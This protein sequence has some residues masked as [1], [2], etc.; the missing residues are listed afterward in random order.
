M[1]GSESTEERHPPRPA[2]GPRSQHRNNIGILRLAFACLVI[3]AHSYEFIDGNRH[4]EPLTRLFGSGVPS[5]GETSVLAFFVISG[6]L[7]T[8]SFISSVKLTNY[9]V[10]R[11]ARIVPGYVVAFLLSSTVVAALAGT[12]L[13]HLTGAELR[14]LFCNL[15]L[16]ES[17]DMPN[18][19]VG[20]PYPFLNGSLWT[21]SYEARCYLFVI[22]FGLLGWHDRRRLYLY[23]TIIL[24]ISTALLDLGLMHVP[25]RFTYSAVGRLFYSDPAWMVRF[26][27]V[28]MIGA[29]FRLFRG[30]ILYRAD[31]AAISVACIAV[32]LYIHVLPFLAMAIFGGYLIFWYGFEQPSSVLS[33]MIDKAD[34]SYG[35]YLYGWPVGILL[36][37]TWRDINPVLL[38]IASLALALPLGWLSWHVVE[39]PAL[40]I[41]T[42]RW[43]RRTPGT[44]PQDTT[45]H[46]AVA[47]AKS[48]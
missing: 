13:V 19:F 45:G 32:S 7:I 10:K 41:A 48:N 9:L 12:D 43:R 33:R 14:H 11:V 47:A 38:I 1:Q 29:C 18:A 8:S 4:R 30:V 39:S 23:A 21:I 24:A 40:A 46:A 42:R 31:W 17:P 34:I 44:E 26:L 2:A 37:W 15:L 6:Y 16:L 3:V 35:V 28:F 5:L 36:L 22:A 20:L 25:G 27:S